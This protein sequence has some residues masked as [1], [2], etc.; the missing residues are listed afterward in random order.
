MELKIQLTESPKQKPCE[1]SLGFGKHFTDH[2]FI[3]DYTREKGWHDARIVPFENL[4]LHPA[5][6]VFH[7]GAEIFEGLKAYRREDGKVQLFRPME[8]I[9]RLNS[10]AD[11]MS[12][13]LLDEDVALEMLT[14]FIEVEQDWV[15]HAKGTSLYIRPFLF[16]ADPFL[17]VHAINRSMFVIIASRAVR[18]TPSAAVTTAHPTERARRLKSSATLRCSGLTELREST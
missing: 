16:G 11:R 7:Y 14:K 9:R 4:C 17:G 15:P 1:D 13:P 5:S 6:T 2:M 12:L 3:M 8:N 18:V 10:S